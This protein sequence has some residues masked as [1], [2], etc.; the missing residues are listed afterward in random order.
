MDLKGASLTVGTALLAG[1]GS[2]ILYNYGKSCYNIYYNKKAHKI[3][4]NELKTVGG[5]GAAFYLL[6]SI[7]GKDSFKKLLENHKEKINKLE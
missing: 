7:L 6:F 1:F 2:S 5:T 4:T 3:N